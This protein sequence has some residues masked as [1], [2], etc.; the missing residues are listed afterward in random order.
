MTDE[1]H[2]DFETR[3]TADLKKVGAHAYFE[4]PSTDLWCAS[5]AFGQGEVRTWRRND[6]P[7]EDVKQYVLATDGP[8]TAWNASFERLAWRHLWGPRHGLPPI[9]ETRFRCTMTEALGMNLPAKLDKAGPAVNSALRKDEGGH[10]L[11]MKM[12]R[13]RR[14]ESDGSVVWWDV[15]EQIDR[16]VAY[17]EQDVRVEREIGNVLLR[18]RPLEVKLYNLDAKINDRGVFIDQ[19]LCQSAQYVVQ[20]SM[21]LLDREM[22]HVTG[23][24]VTGCSNVSDLLKLV[25]QNGFD[26]ESM[27]KENVEDLLAIAE[28]N[29]PML[30]RQALEIRQ[31]GS[32]TSTSKIKAMLARRQTDGR[33]RGNLQFY[34]ASATGRWAARGVQLQNLPRPTIIGSKVNA[35]TPVD[36][37]IETAISYVK[38]GSA[39]MIEA[40][41][42][43]PLTLV[44]DLVRSMLMAPPDKILRSSD[45]SNIEGRVVAWLAGQEDKLDAFRAADAGTGPDLYLVA[46]EGIYNRK[47]GKDD[48]ER[49]IG[50]VAELSLGFQGGP[51]AFAKMAKNYGVRIGELY[52]GIWANSAIEFQERALQGWENRGR[53]TGM[54][55]RGWKAA[56]VIKLAWRAKNWRIAAFWTELEDAALDAVREPGSITQAG[57][58]RFKKNGS[59]LFCLLPSGRGLCYPYPSIETRR[60]KETGRIQT[61]LKFKSVDQYTKKWGDKT[62][63]GGLGVENVTQA[64]ARDVMAEAMLRVEDAGYYPILTIHDEIISE[65]DKDFGSMEEYNALMM[66]SP[67]WAA[68]LPITAAGW[69][70]LRYRKN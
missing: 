20:E 27:D 25:Q 16:L 50:K 64:V 51:R 9:G 30:L 70:G 67:L 46:A 29:M 19:S 49:Q 6:P 14:I 37:Q 56:E 33:I 2:L 58:I 22:R 10:R 38:Q 47:V 66:E 65:T 3:S 34:G 21:K 60:D 18:L 24:R 42:G 54:S 40:A 11:M 41:Y 13:P 68:G 1:L 61:K 32:K 52:D 31:E 12:C 45:F 55:E 23:G 36:Q 39:M 48:K 57:R 28:D 17:C 63:Y 4:H 8:V 53:T 15:A 62:F 5:Y 44:S 69:Q 7:P 43:R 26:T 59:F 35:P